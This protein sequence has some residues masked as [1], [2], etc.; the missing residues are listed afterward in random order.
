MP[1]TNK[2]RDNN[3][4]GE[5]GEVRVIKKWIKMFSANL[6]RSA[7]YLNL[8]P[9][10]PLQLPPPSLSYLTLSHLILLSYFLTIVLSLS[11][12]LSFCVSLTVSSSFEFPWA[13]VSA[14]VL[15]ASS[16]HNCGKGGGLELVGMLEVLA[17]FWEERRILGL[18]LLFSPSLSLVWL[19]CDLWSLTSCLHMGVHGC[20]KGLKVGVL[21]EGFVKKKEMKARKFKGR[22]SVVLNCAQILY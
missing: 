11:R 9:Q 15:T 12:S 10:Q 20:G 5:G 7:H 17:W 2:L 3:A 4:G 1:K 22:A 18:C 8:Q 19:L 21:G 14:R 16:T 6:F 13:D